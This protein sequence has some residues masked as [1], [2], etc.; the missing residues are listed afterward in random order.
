MTPL[1]DI[2]SALQVG[3][4]GGGGDSATALG[5]LVA[6]AGLAL[7]SILSFLI[8]KVRSFT[9]RSGKGKAAADFTSL[10]STGKTIV[11]NRP[12]DEHHSDPPG[13]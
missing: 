13:G 8:L 7:L 1:V 11:A 2:V 5:C 10:R 3:G 4:G 9:R 12:S 6:L